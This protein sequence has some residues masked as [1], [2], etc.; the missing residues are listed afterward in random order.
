MSTRRLF[1]LALALLVPAPP[2][3]AKDVVSIVVVAADGR[4]RIVEPERSVLAVMLYHPK[5]VYNAKPTPAVPR[6]GF[7][8]VYPLGL[9]GMPAIPGRFYPATGALCFA[10]NQ[11]LAP[12]SCARRGV[13]VRLSA[14]ARRL[15]LFHGRPTALRWLDPGGTP[16]LFAAV[17]LA[18]DRY[19]SADAAP[20][21][22]RCRRFTARWHGPGAFRRP[23]EFCVS[24]QGVHARGR[25]YPGTR[26]LWQLARR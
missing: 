14:A 8:K 24:R 1:A 22:R 15:R 11:A 19:Q 12:R 16:N 5:S 13:A 25:L 20:R 10:W 18:F 9:G 26:A 2:A 3:A 4:S 17:E 7:V 6:G 21:P 23:T